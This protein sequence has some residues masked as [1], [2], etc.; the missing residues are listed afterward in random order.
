MNPPPQPS[1]DSGLR[2]YS[3]EHPV[4]RIV[5]FAM[6]VKLKP[7]PVLELQP[8]PAPAKSRLAVNDRRSARYSGEPG[9]A[10]SCFRPSGVNSL[11]A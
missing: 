8:R 7:R 11:S 2:P 3:F 9:G 1:S 6:M 10:L 5:H 4:D